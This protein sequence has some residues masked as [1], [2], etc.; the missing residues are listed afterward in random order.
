MLATSVAELRKQEWA[1]KPAP[2]YPES[3]SWRESERS[4]GEANGGRRRSDRD[5]AEEAPSALHRRY[6]TPFDSQ[7]SRRNHR[8]LLLQAMAGILTFT[9][10]LLF[11]IWGLRNFS[12]QGLIPMNSYFES[13][14]KIFFPSSF[15]NS[16][17]RFEVN[18][19]P[20]LW[21][22]FYFPSHL[23]FNQTIE[24]H[25]LFH[26]FSLQQFHLIRNNLGPDE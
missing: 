13:V 22:R 5:M 15:P 3:R 6:Q 20:S 8:L 25:I 17:G 12:L 18:K 4:I 14:P 26:W 10:Q 11:W 9:L 19:F 24:I 21:I 2:Q 1:S 7:H 16:L 23:R